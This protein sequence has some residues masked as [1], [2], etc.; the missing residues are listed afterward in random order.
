MNEKTLNALRQGMPIISL[1]SLGWVLIAGLDIY[2]KI[3]HVLQKNLS[4]LLQTSG[5]AGQARIIDYFFVLQQ[6]VLIYFLVAPL[7]ITV[8][9]F[10]F[11]SRR[12]LIVFSLLACLFVLL[13]L[14]AN[15]HAWGTVGR[16]LTM[17][18][19]IDA[20]TFATQTP[21]Y[22]AQYISGRSLLKLAVLICL[23]CI[24]HWAAHRVSQNRIMSMLANV[25]FG[26]T[27]VIVLLILGA[28]QASNL[29]ESP[30]NKS[31]LVS[32]IEALGSMRKTTSDNS[33]V[34]SKEALVSQ[35]RELTATKEFSEENPYFGSAKG[36]DLIVLIFETGSSR[37]LDLQKPLNE[38]KTLNALSKNSLMLLNHHST[39]PA[40]AEALFSLHTSMYPTRSLYESCLVSAKKNAHHQIPGFIS[41]L[42]SNGYE[43]A[44]YVPYKDVMPIDI[45][46][47]GG[48]GFTRMSVGEESTNYQAGRT[49]NADKATLEILKSD[50]AAWIHSGKH[51]AAVF[52]PQIG[53]APWKERPDTKTIAD[54]GKDLIKVQDAWLGE[55]VKLLNEN[56]RLDKTVILV[57]GDHGIRTLR[58]DPGLNA[59]YIDEYSFHVPLLLYSK[60]SFSQPTY[61]ETLTSHIDVSPSL[62]DILGIAR[63]KRSEQGQAFWSTGI[64]SR[65]TAFLAD[66][67]FAA[68]GYYRNGQYSMFTN[69]LGLGFR[70]NRLHFG[71]S[72]LIKSQE[73]S[74]G[75]SRFIHKLYGLQ[76]S[77]L[78]QFIC[79][80]PS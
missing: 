13:L 29:R 36:S 71:H 26:A 5:E 25:A 80:A 35:Y 8:L 48:Y 77:W 14:F 61:I 70:N 1:L 47:H 3:L 42:A 22:I 76:Q 78:Q 6:D 69:T 66:W 53:H 32:A 11:S 46:L 59:G 79:S 12:R 4:L 52:L 49:K 34:S 33:L 67:Y 65:S 41:S 27:L 57:A 39:F 44:L 37:F 9:Y 51:Y 7:V 10:C 55:V 72:N 40:T 64:S 75:V 15:L 20:A 73:E 30:A 50:L 56:G 68:D 54:H 28:A 16:F 63:D 31:F 19:A 74:D 2:L 45:A 21:S 62:L 23:V 58:E 24:T 18:A 60:N 17:T 43:T 38:F